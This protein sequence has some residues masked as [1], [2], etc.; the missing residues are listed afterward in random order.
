M[1]KII[2]A[3]VAI[4][5]AA[6]VLVY[7]YM[8]ER[9]RWTTE[10]DYTGLARE[11]RN[12]ELVSESDPAVAMRFAPSFRYLGGQ[13]FVLY[14]VAGVEQHF[15]AETTTEGAL[16]SVYWIQF[17]EYLPDNS[18]RYDYE[19]SPGR[20]SIGAFD[21]YVDTAAVQ[22]DPKSRRRGTDGARAREFL[23]SRGFVLP[24][25]YVYARLVHLTDESRRK[26]LMVIFIEDL[27]PL[28]LNGSHLVDGGREA[29][30]W[31][32]IEKNHIE[33]IRRTMALRRPDGK[34]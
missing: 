3:A 11:V 14:G 33:R 31:P 30:R 19:D 15:F 34:S 24:A 4:L 10:A 9:G 17:E 29:G 1:K 12:G 22:S 23:M 2:L 28:G 27:A 18:H 5:V 16:E 8:S 25:N 6:G 20:L 26:E 21:F 7:L 13:K 32:A